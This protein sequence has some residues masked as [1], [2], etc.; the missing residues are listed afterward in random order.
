MFDLRDNK[1]AIINPKVGD[2]VIANKTDE[3]VIEFKSQHEIQQ[4]NDLITK[5]KG[6]SEESDLDED[7]P[8]KINKASAAKSAPCSWKFHTDQKGD[9]L[10][11]SGYRIVLTYNKV[12]FYNNT[13]DKVA[14]LLL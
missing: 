8:A 11:K 4:Q 1:V 9:E 13:Q 2:K 14:N 5:G 12:K 3:K 6:E 10:F 7:K